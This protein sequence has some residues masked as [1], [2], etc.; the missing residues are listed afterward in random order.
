V[1][2]LVNEA[3][4]KRAAAV[5][6]L[7]AI[8]FVVIAPAF[9]YGSVQLSV[10]GG[11]E[12]TADRLL[13][14]FGRIEAHAN[15]LRGSGWVTLAN[16]SSAFDLLSQD[17]EYRIASGLVGTGKY[18]GLRLSITNATMVKEGKSTQLIAQRFIIASGNF[19]VRFAQTTPLT[20]V[21]A[22]DPGKLETQHRLEASIS[23]KSELP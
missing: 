15:T 18:D 6:G 4:L 5:V 12:V 7:L 22:V 17:R 10:E 11:R 8:L 16:S 1:A 13:I 23:I 19:T 9:S 20:L 14:Q 21:I 3:S 2:D